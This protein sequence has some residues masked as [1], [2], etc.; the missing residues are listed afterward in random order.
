MMRWRRAASPEPEILAAVD[1]GS[2]SFHMVV[3]RLTHGQ[4]TVIDRLREMVQLAAALDEKNQIDPDG[5]ARALA[6]LERFGERIRDMRADRV[7]VVGTNTLRRARD[8]GAFRRLAA[9]RLGHPVEIISGIEEARLIYLGASHSLPMADGLQVMLDIGGGSTEIVLGHHYEPQSME[10]L[11]IGCISISK[12]YFSD[13]KLSAKRFERARV[14]ARLELEPFRAIYGRREV[15]RFVGTSGT[16]RAVHRILSADDG[17]PNSF[18]I[19]AVHE[20]IEQMIDAGRLERLQFKG[21]SDR[22]RGVITG[23][24]AILVEAMD[25]LNAR[26]LVVSDGALKE[27]ILYDM[28]GRLTD[29]DAR[30]RTARSL[31]ARYNVDADQGSRVEQTALALIDQVAGKWG[32][33]D[34]DRQMLSWAAR[35]HELGLGIAHSHY[36]HHG[37]YLL[38]YADMPGFTKEDQRVLALLVKGHRRSLDPTP[39]R[40]LPDPWSRRA[41]RLTVI[42][43]L[44]VLLNRS[45]VDTG[46]PSL[47]LQ[48]RGKKL[49]IRVD[50]DWRDAHT[51]TMAGL[52]RERKYLADAGLE[53]TI[54]ELPAV[55][56]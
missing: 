8:A 28:V 4:I 32:L 56:P 52:Q 25:A 1:L 9:E 6:C 19:D 42:L 13:G 36:H 26:E 47:Q 7:R 24:V 39:Y 51:L 5:Q 17:L 21:L 55:R 50:A 3:A 34:E 16:V 37:A 45:R 31:Q 2:N 22:R 18:G 43:R 44:A 33:G 30:E 38:E 46:R 54:G 12:E 20:L 23:G 41:L 11:Y 53:I 40:E 49:V 48:A 35:L 29:E 10:S 27:G 14:A 15:E